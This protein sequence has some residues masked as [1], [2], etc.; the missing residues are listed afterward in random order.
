M[1]RLRV[2]AGRI[3]GPVRG[4]TMIAPWA[5]NFIG[6]PFQDHGRDFSGVDCYGLVHLV[7]SQVYRVVL[8]EWTEIYSDVSPGRELQAAMDTGR[9]LD[10]WWNR[11]RE[12][13]RTGDVVVLR[14]NGFFC[15]CGIVV[16]A[17]AGFFLHA[18]HQAGAIIESWR[19]PK[20]ASRIG[21]FVYHSK[22]EYTNPR[23][24]RYSATRKPGHNV[25]AKVAIAP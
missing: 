14:I 25:P 11:N 22:A 21:Y 24:P 12:H 20:W 7:Y 3:P 18:E 4:V 6:I 1:A 17:Q 10:H 13:P 23:K 19:T 16:D 9:G 8:N 2:L 5:E 15:H